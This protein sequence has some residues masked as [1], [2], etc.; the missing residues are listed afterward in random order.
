MIDKPQ[1]RAS[2]DDAVRIDIRLDGDYGLVQGAPAFEP[3]ST[4]R[5]DVTVTAMEALQCKGIDIAIGWRTEGRGD[6]DRD[7]IFSTRETPD[8][9]QP[10]LPNRYRHSV[11]LPQTPIS[12]AGNLISIVWMVSVK[13]DLP[14]GGDP[15]DDLIFIVR[16]PAA[17]SA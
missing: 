6:T 14:R 17:E 9:L 4:L 7:T 10:G 2:S 3:G 16:A 15:S 5:L 13:V 12:Y 8:T 11:S 1:R